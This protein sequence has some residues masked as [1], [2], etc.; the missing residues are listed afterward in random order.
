VIVAKVS[1]DRMRET[2][3]FSCNISF[4]HRGAL[5]AYP[6]GV[7]GVAFPAFV[8]LRGKLRM[9]CEERRWHAISSVSGIAPLAPN[10]FIRQ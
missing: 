2:Q 10:T 1:S 5:S 6:R 3:V 8:P 4:P 9:D 7:G